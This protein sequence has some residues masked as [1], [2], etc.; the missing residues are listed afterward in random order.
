MYKMESYRASKEPD[1][2]TWLALDESHRLVLIEEYVEEFEKEISDEAIRIHASAHLT[3]ENQLAMNEK[4]TVDAY[5]R[6]RRQGL[7]RH[8]TIHAIGAIIIEDIYEVV[9][10]DQPSF[11]YK[12]RLRKLTAKRWLKGKY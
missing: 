9:N 8:E 11:R 3:V 6:L 4:E 1:P 10:N 7:K 12:N 2:A 5:L